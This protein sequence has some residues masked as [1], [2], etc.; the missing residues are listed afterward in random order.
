[1]AF[2]AKPAAL[3]AISTPAHACG[4]SDVTE[5]A[6]LAEAGGYPVACAYLAKLRRINPGTVLGPARIEQIK[7]LAAASGAGCVL[8]ASDLRP[9]QQR[10]LADALGLEVVDRTGLI[11]HIFAARAHTAEGRLQ[12]ELARSQYELARLAG[13]WTHLERQRGATRATG[14]PGEM[15]IEIDRRLLLQR[16]GRLEAKLAKRLQRAKQAVRRR[17]QGIAS[18]A[19]VGYTNAGKSTLFARLAK[20]R[21][22][23]SA[24]LFETL[25][26]TT[27][28]IYLGDGQ[29]AA[30]SDTV[31]FLR[32]LPHSLIAAFRATLH[33]AVDADLLLI[34]VDCSD[35]QAEAKLEAVESTLS[36]IG[37]DS[38]PRMLVFN[39]SDLARQNGDGSFD[40]LHYGKIPA[41][42]VSAATG[43]GIPELREQLH[44]RLSTS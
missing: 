25:D 15:Q 44:K 40:W 12:V 24:R 36:E 39:K 32:D 3:L 20:E 38:V 1:M 41:A 9:A 43:S 6:A 35:P 27:R 28:R 34:V 22:R 23:A 7:Q 33:E 19:L 13:S 16:I 26:T 2:V 17:R 10:R 30:L 18:I 4:W 37:A 14:G 29:Y 5:L 8:A 42:S 11:L 21:T 31:G